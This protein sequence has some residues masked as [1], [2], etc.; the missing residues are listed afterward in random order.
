MS[1]RRRGRVNRGRNQRRRTHGAQA[2]EGAGLRN[3]GAGRTHG[4]IRSNGTGGTGG[5][6]LSPNGPHRACRR[7]RL[8]LMPAHDRTG[9]GAELGH[10]EEERDQGTHLENA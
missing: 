4:A 6:C 2:G 8:Q 10:E 1:K 7:R 3:G 9:H 5:G